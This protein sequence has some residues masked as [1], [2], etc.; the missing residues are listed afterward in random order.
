MTN[1]WQFQVTSP[2][3]QAYLPLIYIKLRVSQNT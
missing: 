1:K 3:R 2:K